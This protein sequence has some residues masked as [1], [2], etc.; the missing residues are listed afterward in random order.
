[1]F[2]FCSH[3]RETSGTALWTENFRHFCL[4]TFSNWVEPNF[5]QEI[6]MVFMGPPTHLWLC[7]MK[8]VFLLPADPPGGLALTE[9]LLES[10]HYTHRG[11][12]AKIPDLKE[13][14]SFLFFLKPPSCMYS[15]ANGLIWLWLLLY[16]HSLWSWPICI[17]LSVFCD[18]LHWIHQDHI[19]SSQGP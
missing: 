11:Q 9:H 3:S 16:P 15:L 8:E 14:L 18:W 5:G 1:M 12:Q 17:P 19:R 7:K 2:G 13:F 10:I 4:S 6:R